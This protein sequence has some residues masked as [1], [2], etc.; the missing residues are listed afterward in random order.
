MMKIRRTA[1]FFLFG[2]FFIGAV[3]LSALSWPVNNPVITS[4]FSS[5][6]RDGFRSAL[7]LHAENNEIYA[8]ADGTVVY[9]YNCEK[10]EIG[11]SYIIIEHS[12]GLRSIYRGITPKA[13][14]GVFVSE[15][16]LIAYGEYVSLEI[17][18]IESM[19]IV[20]PERLLP[21]IPDKEAPMVSSVLLRKG[22]QYVNPE[23]VEAV[24]AGKYH[25]LIAVNDPRD[26]YEL[27]PY[28][29]V[30]YFGGIKQTEYIFDTLLF[31][32]S[33]YIFDSGNELDTVF[34]TIGGHVYV[35][36]GEIRLLPGEQ[37]FELYISDCSENTMEFSLSVIIVKE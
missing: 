17:L 22:R 13:K 36:L 23:E 2:F 30:M 33:E 35:D 20:N 3:N 16:D 7:I 14:L 31:K 34:L 1:V 11:Q 28:K 19:E 32:N 6:L 27:F 5:M 37:N 18:D 21:L 4:S 29:I 24:G 25:F 10:P 12:D 9:V 26:A 15:G 8:I